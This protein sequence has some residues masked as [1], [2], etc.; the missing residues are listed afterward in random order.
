M[1]GS[2][3]Q[4]K[5]ETE[6]KVLTINP[7]ERKKHRGNFFKGTRNKYIKYGHSASYFWGNINK[8]NKNKNKVNPVSTK[9]VTI[10]GERA[11]GKLIV[12]QRRKRKNMELTTYFWVH[13]LWRIIVKLQR[14]RPHIM[15]GRQRC[16]IIH[17]IHEINMTNI[18][19]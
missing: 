14:R 9:N 8:G 4:E 7:G 1:G 18:E 13:I 5:Q 16:V 11:T 10:Q 19:E 12:G 15:V 2:N 3:K 17:P 6:D